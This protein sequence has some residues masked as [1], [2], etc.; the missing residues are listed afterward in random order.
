MR[1]EP[2]LIV[3]DGQAQ[4]RESA[5][6]RGERDAHLYP[7][8]QRDREQQGSTEVRDWLDCLVRPTAEHLAE[9]GSPTWWA[10]FGAQVMTDPALREI[11]SDEAM[12]SP[13]LQRILEGLNAC[14]PT[15]PVEIRLERGDVGRHLMVHMPA[16]R[17]RAI[18][19]GTH[20][21]RATWADAATGLV[22]ALVGVWLAPV[23]PSGG[24][25]AP[26]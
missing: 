22:D 7:G 26:S 19:E 12:N 5:Q 16:E 14:L 8:D 15:L 20:T 24:A 21:P 1:G 4:A 11:M 2:D 9:L 17:E 25:R 23:T 3:R 13:A 18:A 6:Q 10:R